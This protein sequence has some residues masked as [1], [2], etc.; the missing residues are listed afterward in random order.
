MLLARIISI[1]NVAVTI[2]IVTGVL[3]TAFGIL[4]MPAQELVIE[5]KLNDHM[6]GQIDTNNKLDVLICLQ[7]K[8]ETPLRCIARE[9]R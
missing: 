2:I 4:K 3:V 5:Q 9:R 6:R 1:R 8:L 7:A